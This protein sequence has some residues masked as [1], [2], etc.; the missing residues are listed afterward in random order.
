V[1]YSKSGV[2]CSTG[3]EPGPRLIR[4]DGVSMNWWTTTGR[5][6]RISME[7]AVR[8]RHAKRGNVEETVSRIRL[9]MR[10]LFRRSG[11]MIGPAYRQRR[12]DG[13]MLCHLVVTGHRLRRTTRQ[14]AL[15]AATGV[16]QSDAPQPGPHHYFSSSWV[17]FRPLK[18]KSE[19][20]VDLR[21][22]PNDDNG[23]ILMARW[24]VISPR[25]FDCRSSQLGWRPGGAAAPRRG[26]G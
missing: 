10:G 7:T 23:A 5:P 12:N 4:G 6:R 2:R 3:A 16:Q 24:W 21:Y 19:P 18:K 1:E 8:I 20:D 26:C 13:M 11:A 17:D 22:G 14:C 9:A 15:P 25:L